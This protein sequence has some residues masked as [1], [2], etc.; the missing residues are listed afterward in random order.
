MAVD[1]FTPVIGEQP[2]AA[3]AAEKLLLL[4]EPAGA[5]TFALH[6]SPRHYTACCPHVPIPSE[7]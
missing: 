4:Y 2:C 3:A 6:D 5:V 1:A 7:V